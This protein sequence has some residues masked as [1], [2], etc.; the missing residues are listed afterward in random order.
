MAPISP[1]CTC[2]L[3]TM[4]PRT[5][6]GLSAADRA[7]PTTKTAIMMTATRM[8][9]MQMSAHPPELR[10]HALPRTQ[11]TRAQ[12]A[13][14][15]LARCSSRK[16]DTRRPSYVSLQPKTRAKA[17]SCLALPRAPR[18]RKQSRIVI[19]SRLRRPSQREGPWQGRK[20]AEDRRG[21]RGR[22]SGGPR[23]QA[24]GVRISRRRRSARRRGR[25]S[26]D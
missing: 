25:R 18:T 11:S 5:C 13:I 22:G 2:R 1:H 10:S 9:T 16:D 17:K 15:M 4:H 24:R 23:Q 20:Q 14:R 26:R 19:E 8:T 7:I 6:R 12:T 3:P 21:C